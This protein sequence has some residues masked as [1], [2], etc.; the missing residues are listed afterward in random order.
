[1][2]AALIRWSAR[3]VVLVGIATVFLTLACIKICAS[4]LFAGF[5]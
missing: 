3:N 5:C 4:A 1:M 2:I